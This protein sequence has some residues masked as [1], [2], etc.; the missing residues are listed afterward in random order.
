MKNNGGDSY[1]MILQSSK[2]INNNDDDDKSNSRWNTSSRTFVVL[3]V[4]ALTYPFS[5]AG[6]ANIQPTFWRFNIPVI[7]FTASYQYKK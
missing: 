7:A 3:V 2:H 6:C 5:R 1:K 4:L